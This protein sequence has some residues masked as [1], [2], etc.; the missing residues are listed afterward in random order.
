VLL[1]ENRPSSVQTI[2]WAA[3]FGLSSSCSILLPL[4]MALR[5][6]KWVLPSFK[7]L[8]MALENLGETTKLEQVVLEHLAEA[9]LGA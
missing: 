1:C 3:K 2:V 6:A 5:H 8:S 7:S 9:E 4:L